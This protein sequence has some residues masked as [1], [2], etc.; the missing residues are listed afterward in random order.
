MAVTVEKILLAQITEVNL[1]GN[2]TKSASINVT[3]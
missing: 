3:T 1:A 2:N